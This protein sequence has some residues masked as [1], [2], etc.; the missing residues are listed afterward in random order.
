M[1]YNLSKFNY[2][3]E[4]KKLNELGGFSRGISKH[5]PRNDRKLFDKGKY[6]FVQT[7]DIKSANLYINSHNQ[8]Y[9]EFGLKQSKLWDKN[10]LCITIAANIAETAILKYPMCFP[11]SIVG[12]NSYDGISSELFMHYIFQFIK[13]SIQNSASGSI[14]DNINI[15]YLTN[16]E[17]KI[18]S[19]E[20]QNKIVNILGDIDKKIENNNEINNNLQHQAESIYLHSFFGK[21][22]NGNLKQILL[23]NSKSS[24][25]VNK[26]KEM[27]AEY[28]F[29]TSGNAIYS[30]K[31]YLV[32]GRN[33]FINTGGN[34]GIK[35]YV[36]KS[37]YSTDTW[38]ITG[39]DRFSDYLYMFLNSIKVEIN[40]VYFQGTGLKHLQKPMLKERKIYIPTENELA[41][42]NDKVVPMFTMISNNLE[43]NNRLIALRD[44]LLPLLMNG[45]ATIEE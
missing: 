16:L 7:G 8:E 35:F 2:G 27:N 38:C 1:I 22:N 32:D 33:C 37:A 29:F 12:F 34:A 36:G 5:R 21:K 44:F 9:N 20:Y 3:W 14:Q 24:I 15:N 41:E 39:R 17:F 40:K 28:P 13:S 30:W 4:T 23:E 18:P 45:Q 10:T 43:K 26:A 6:P 11:D 25:Q 19:F 42:F 31:E